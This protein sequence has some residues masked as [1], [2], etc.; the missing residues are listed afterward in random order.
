TENTFGSV[1]ELV[2]AKSMD[3]I[4]KKEPNRI[5]EMEDVYCN[6]LKTISATKVPS[7]DLPSAKDY[8]REW[9]KVIVP[10]LGK[11]LGNKVTSLIESIADED[12]LIH[13]DCHMKNIFVTNGEPLLIDMETISRGNH[14]FEYAPLYGSFFVYEMAIPDNDLKFFGLPAEVV[15]PFFMNAFR[16][17]YS[18]KS[19]EEFAQMV[20]QL[21]FVA[22]CLIL[23][24]TLTFTPDDERLLGVA[25]S[26]IEEGVEKLDHLGL[27]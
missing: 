6:L 2:D 23:Y 10:Y 8:G 12:C 19:E 20:T 1:F 24:R 14:I 18:G 16:S 11:D 3:S 22:G 13:G 5:K 17:I 26:L 15:Q 25:K 27:D 9:L 7:N 4:M 21:R